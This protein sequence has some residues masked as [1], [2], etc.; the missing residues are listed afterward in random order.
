MVDLTANAVTALAEPEYADCLPSAVTVDQL[1][2]LDRVTFSTGELRALHSI[3]P[4]S[5][6]IPISLRKRDPTTWPSEHSLAN[7]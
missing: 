2:E 6:S 4:R 7:E 1:H 3:D 5:L